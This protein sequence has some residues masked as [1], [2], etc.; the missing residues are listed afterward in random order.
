MRAK[1]LLQIIICAGKLGDALAMKETWP[2]ALGDFTD[3]L[4]CGYKDTGC[5]LVA[6]HCP[7]QTTQA[8][9]DGCLPTLLLLE[10]VA[11]RP[12]ARRDFKRLSACDT[13][14]FFR[15]ARGLQ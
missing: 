3:V 15:P 14:P 8:A 10:A 2:V 1:K 4:E 12:R 11:A 7:Q 13:A 9:L 6:G 5:R